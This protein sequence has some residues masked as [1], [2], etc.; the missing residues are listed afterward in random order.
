MQII[1]PMAGIGK[2]FIKEGYNK[3]KPLIEVEEKPIIQHV[4]SLFPKE[5]NYIFICN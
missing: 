4:C 1:V 2:R 5:E 3:P